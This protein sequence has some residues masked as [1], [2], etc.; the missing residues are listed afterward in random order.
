MTGRSTKRK[1]SIDLT[2]AGAAGEDQDHQPAEKKQRTDAGGGDGSG[3]VDITPAP[4][5][6]VTERSAKR[7]A[8]ADLVTAGAAGDGQDHQPSE[9]KQKT[10][11]DGDDGSGGGDAAA[12]ATTTTQNEPVEEN[13][14]WPSLQDMINDSNNDQIDDLF[15]F[16]DDNINDENTNID[17]TNNND[18][19]DND[20]NNNTTTTNND[21]SI[22]QPTDT[23]GNDTNP[24]P[25]PNSPNLPL[26][27]DGQSGPEVSDMTAVPASNAP[28]MNQ[29]TTN[30]GNDNTMF[31][32]LDEIRPPGEE[33]NMTGN[34]D[35]VDL[36]S[37]QM[38]AGTSTFDLFFNS[39]EDMNPAGG[40]DS[41][42][43]GDNNNNSGNSW[44]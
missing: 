4:S 25:N 36:D 3:G 19:D 17:N 1:A 26:Q 11:S 33:T 41:Y 43:P 20:N 22:N 42:M 40:T 18:N 7:R 31:S 5:N 28:E 30:A 27:M 13:I 24:I 2:T 37:M 8:S 6:D 12:A 23:S 29:A 16:T 38:G 32:S 15:D 14:D 44:Q 10:D 39:F 9:K 21:A 34:P 35:S